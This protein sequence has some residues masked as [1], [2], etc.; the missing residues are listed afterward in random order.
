MPLPR[1]VLSVPNG[2]T[3][4]SPGHLRIGR[5]TDLEIQLDDPS[6]SRLHAEVYLHD[7]GWMIR[8]RGSSN[9]TQ[10]NGVRIGRTPQKLEVGDLIHIGTFRLHVDQLQERPASIRV[11]GRAV[12]IEASSGWS[13]EDGPDPWEPS[14]PRAAAGGGAM[15]LMRAGLRLANAQHPDLA[16]QGLLGE[17]VRFFQARRCGLFLCGEEGLLTLKCFTASSS[18]SVRPPGKTLPAAALRRRQSLQFKDS[19]EA[20]RLQADSAVKGELGSVMCAVLHT[21]E[22]EMGVLYLDRATGSPPFADVDLY[23]ADSIAAAL[24]LGLDRRHLIA[25]HQNF[26]LQT[27]TALAQAV[28]MRDRYTGNHTYRVTA[29]SVMLAVELGLSPEQRRQLQVATA[30]HDIGKIAIDDQILRKPDRLSEDEFEQMK[31]HVLRGAEIIQMIPGL[32]WA[33]PVVRGHHERW[34]GMGYPDGLEG[35]ANPLPARIV[36]VA[37]AFDAM[38]SDRPYRKGMPSERAFS[39]LQNGSGSHFDPVCVAAFLR[40]RPKIEE[41]LEREAAERGRVAK[42]TDTISRKQLEAEIATPAE[43]TSD[44]AEVAALP[45]TAIFHGNARPNK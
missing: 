9:G 25:Q 24:A 42:A 7:D 27:V 31:T 34:D 4:S 20:V 29:Y 38:T 19:S 41:L 23:T 17:T 13:W 21:P 6:V 35:E 8:D 18:T 45:P 10:V 22:R 15:R 39:E 33:L 16:L 40:I 3:W 1:V 37:D 5:L 14:D 28:E 43:N 30:L 36:A 32:G 26:F 12:Q 11:G 44:T 2:Q